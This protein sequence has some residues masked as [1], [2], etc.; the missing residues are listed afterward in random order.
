MIKKPYGLE[1]QFSLFNQ[2]N[3]YADLCKDLKRT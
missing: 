3:K 1:M 2:R